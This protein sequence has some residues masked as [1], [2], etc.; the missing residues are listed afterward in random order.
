[1]EQKEKMYK[2]ET[3][4]VNLVC[5]I[6]GRPHCEKHGAMLAVVPMSKLYRCSECGIGID[7]NGIFSFIEYVLRGKEK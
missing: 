4:Y 1:M 7:T 6:D 5:F 3:S 2:R